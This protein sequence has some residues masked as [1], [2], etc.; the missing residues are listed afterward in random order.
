MDG[1][2]ETPEVPLGR[3][4]WWASLWVVP[5]DVKPDGKGKSKERW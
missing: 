5:V 2:S 4:A 1:L 3:S